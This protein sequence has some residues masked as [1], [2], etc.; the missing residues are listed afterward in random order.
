MTTSDKADRPLG[1]HPD[2]TTPIPR[3]SRYYGRRN[4]PPAHEHLRK[5]R[6][7]AEREAAPPLAPET[8]D[9]AGRIDKS[10][11]ALGE[12][13]RIRDK[14]HL[15]YVASQPCILCGRQPCDAHH[16][17]FAQPRATGLKVSDEFTVPLCRT[18]H[19]Q[20]HDAGNEVSWWEDLE[21]NALKIARGLWEENH[22][23]LRNTVGENSDTIT[24]VGSLKGDSTN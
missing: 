6:R 7:K 13:K 24:Q 19:R 1:L 12:P 2:D 21:I 16:L 14:E 17:R 11:L 22:A 18:H 4:D 23:Q 15:K 20:L 5:D 9:S 8:S 10:Q 3:P